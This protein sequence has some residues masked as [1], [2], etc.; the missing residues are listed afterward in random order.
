MKPFGSRSRFVVSRMLL[1]HSVVKVGGLAL[2]PDSPGQEPW[3][4]LLLVVYLERPHDCSDFIFSS[5]K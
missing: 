5:V 3:I 4:Y 2:E 1:G